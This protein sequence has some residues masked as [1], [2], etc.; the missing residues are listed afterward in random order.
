MPSSIALSNAV[1]TANLHLHAFA[2]ARA[3]L[4]TL[5]MRSLGVDL[6]TVRTGVAV[7]DSEVAVATPLCT[8]H[9]RSLPEIIAAVAALIAK[10]QIGE[11]VLGLPL[12]LGGR[13]GDSAR[14][15]RQFARALASQTSVPV[16]LWDE[17][18]SSVAAERS[19]RE[20]GV[21]RG[22]RRAVVDQVAA[23][24]LLQSYLDQ[25]A[26]APLSAAGEADES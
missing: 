1:R 7:A 13:E 18:L 24:L 17:R 5:P 14:R 4:Y 6:G 25:R 23:T 3:A 11:V 22:Q 15:V 10:E 26:R 20:Q 16:R 12:Q 2:K 9:H 21:R 19:L 8:L